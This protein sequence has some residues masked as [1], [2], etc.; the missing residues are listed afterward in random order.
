MNLALIWYV[1][2]CLSVVFYVV[3]DG[4][5]LGVGCLHLFVKTDR[6]RRIL[7]NAIGP[8]WDGNEVWII[9]V[10]GGLLAGFPPVY[11]TLCSSFYNLIMILIAGLMFRA[12][13]IEFRSKIASVGWRKTWDLTFSLASYIIAFCIGLLLANLV[14]GIAIDKH[15][16]FTGSFWDFFSPYTVLV[17]L[18]GI[19]LFMMHAIVYLLM[20]TEGAL[21]AKI[22]KWLLPTLGVFFFFYVTITLL[23]MLHH[24]HMT[25]LM[26]KNPALFFVGVLALFATLCI[27]YAVYKGRNGWAFLASSLAIALLLAL[28]SIGT[29]PLMIRSKMDPA[30][31]LT[32]A[33]AASS[34]ATLKIILLIAA[35]GV[36]FVIGYGFWIYRT[37]RGKV[38][39]EESSY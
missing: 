34:E 18:T 10:F 15:G 23:T 5:D 11:A 22:Q 31:S 25:A 28:F 24:P 38:K 20:K 26:R 35:I 21:Y 17:G 6:D 4:F 14:E 1:I 39:L 16:N 37:F 36:P 29:F 3:L 33:N 32:F 12:A 2:L 19:S 13:S 30:W 7:L 9:I 8:V 27:P